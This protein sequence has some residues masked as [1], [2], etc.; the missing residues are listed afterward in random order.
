MCDA[1]VV[2]TWA[3]P[4]R[5]CD[6][7]TKLD[8]LAKRYQEAC[9]LALKDAPIHIDPR[10]LGISKL[11]RL[12]NISQVHNVILASC[13]KEGHDP[14]R[15]LVGVC[16]VHKDP[17]AIQAL[18]EL[19]KQL[20]ESSPLMPPVWED[21]MRYEILACNHYNTA[22]RLGRDNCQSPAGDLV[23]LRDKDS[24]YNEA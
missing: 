14:S 19:N 12:F 21:L 7:P 18:V 5:T 4:A 16:M 9:A 6:D 13:V 11:N 8:K 23:A 10:Y 20:A 22:L 15:P 1:R 17:K 3:R 2:K 24:S